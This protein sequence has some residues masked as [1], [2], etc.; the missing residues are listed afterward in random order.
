MFETTD[1]SFRLSEKRKKS[2]EKNLMEEKSDN[3]SSERKY[4]WKNFIMPKM[5]SGK[6]Y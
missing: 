3:L 1:E 6:R 2:E 4:F 5:D